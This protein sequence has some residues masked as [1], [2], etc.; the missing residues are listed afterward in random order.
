MCFYCMFNE[1]ASHA[2]E[3]DRYTWCVAFSFWLMFEKERD[4]CLS[5]SFS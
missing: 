2:L 5:L 1:R 4:I 3:K